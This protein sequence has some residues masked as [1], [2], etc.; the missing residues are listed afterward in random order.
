MKIADQ[1][2][3][4]EST[5]GPA[6]PVPADPQPGLLTFPSGLPGFEQKKGYVLLAKPDEAP[7]LRLQMVGDPNIS[8]VAIAPAAVLDHYRPDLSPDDVLALG[9]HDPAD[10]LVFNI[11]TVHPDGVATVN[12]KGPVVVNRQ[13]LVGRQVVPLNAAAW[14]LAHPLPAAS[15]ERRA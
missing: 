10:A 13:T 15:A 4:D 8:F 11:V 3:I 7:F 12:L 2:L 6:A 5:G 14:P 1:T 9:L